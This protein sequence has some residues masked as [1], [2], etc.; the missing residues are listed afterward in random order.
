MTKWHQIT[1][2][3]EV[4]FGFA[5]TN[6]PYAFDKL[7]TNNTWISQPIALVHVHKLIKKTDVI[8]WDNC[9]DTELTKVQI[10]SIMQED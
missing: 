1:Q 10:F 4:R 3:K 2:G 8:K 7:V 9:V 5:N 6:A